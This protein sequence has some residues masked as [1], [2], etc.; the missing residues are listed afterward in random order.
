[1]S[2]AGSPC[3]RSVEMELR[4]KW[5]V[6]SYFELIILSLDCSLEL[7]LKDV[8]VDKDHQMRLS[9]SDEELVKD[10]KLDKIFV[11]DHQFALN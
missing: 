1:M 9:E 8:P 6:T 2:P 3:T 4:Q 7:R 11:I 10:V 5:K